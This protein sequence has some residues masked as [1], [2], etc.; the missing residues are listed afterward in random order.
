MNLAVWLDILADIYIYILAIFLAL[1]WEN[2]STCLDIELCIWS[3]SHEISH[4][5]CFVV[6]FCGLVLICDTYTYP[7]GLIYRQWGHPTMTP[8]PVNQPWRIWVY[9]SY[10]CARTD[11]ITKTKQT[12][13][14]PCTYFNGIYC[15]A[16]CAKPNMYKT[17]RRNRYKDKIYSLIFHLV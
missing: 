10:G 5:F 14:T 2:F 9:I 17:T 7:T 12:K 4:G 3:I 16:L 11:D 13:T 15:I 6:F 1:I 8:L